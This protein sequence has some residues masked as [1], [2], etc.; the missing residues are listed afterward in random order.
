[1]YK[2]KDSL[3]SNINGVYIGTDGISIGSLLPN[4]NVPRFK[5]TNG[6]VLTATSG[7]IGG[8]TIGRYEL[9]SNN[10]YISSSGSIRHQNGDTSNWGISS[11]GYAYFKNVFISGVDDDSSFG[12]MYL[13]SDGWTFYDSDS[14][15]PF[16]G[17]CKLHIEELAVDKIVAEKAIIGWLDADDI[18]TD[19]LS[20]NRIYV[21]SLKFNGQD[22]TWGEITY[23]TGVSLSVEDQRS[24]DLATEPGG[25]CFVVDTDGI[26]QFIPTDV[27]HTSINYYKTLKLTVS[28]QK[29][30]V[31]G[32]KSATGSTSTV[33]IISI[34]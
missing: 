14:L 26:T 21:D 15:S 27:G 12:Q 23:V 5:V 3:D 8:W 19:L 2:D 25:S 4:S 31:L 9:S 32:T 17:N 30:T 33:D 16:T 13:N 10:I 24:A 11:S 18:T 28:K 1:L 22:V 20:A 6:G 34:E 7:N 29:S